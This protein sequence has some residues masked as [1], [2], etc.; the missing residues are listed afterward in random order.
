MIKCF[1]CPTDAIYTIADSGANPVSYCVN[2]LPIWLR[3]RAIA[4]AFPLLGAEKETSKPSKK[5]E[6]PAEAPAEEAPA[7]ENN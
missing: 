2:C 5:K 4:G 6:A 7:D 1:N 3:D